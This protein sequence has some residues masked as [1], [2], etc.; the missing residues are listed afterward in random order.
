MP[1]FEGCDMT[2]RQ[3]AW[4]AVDIVIDL[5]KKHGIKYRRGDFEFVEASVDIVT[6][7]E[8]GLVRERNLVVADLLGVTV[9]LRC[10]FPRTKKKLK[11]KKHRFSQYACCTVGFAGVYFKFSID[12][13]NGEAPYRVQ[14]WS[15]LKAEPIDEEETACV[16]CSACLCRGCELWWRGKCPYGHCYDSHRAKV[17]PYDVYHPGRPPRT[18][19]SEWYKDQAF[20]CRGGIFYSCKECEHYVPYKRE[21]QTSLFDFT[22]EKRGLES[23]GYPS[24]WVDEVVDRNNKYAVF[25]KDG[26]PHYKSQ[27]P[28]YEG[29]WLLGGLGSVQCAAHDGLIPGLQWDKFC[30]KCHKSC[31]VFRKE[32]GQN[33][34]RDNEFNRGEDA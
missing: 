20:W 6:E 34:R 28:C 2:A 23:R 26:K 4:A 29:Y 9:A 13:L 27:C 3:C 10:D 22:E 17:K 12:E 31:L 21:E 19:W 25:E 8:K 30:S 7:S 1:N 32:T 11:E 18:G 33:N 14:R 16:G 15:E 24:A 5:A